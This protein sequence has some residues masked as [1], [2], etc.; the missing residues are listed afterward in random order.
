LLWYIFTLFRYTWLRYRTSMAKKEAIYCSNCS[1][2]KCYYIFF[3]II[4]PILEILRNW[5]WFTAYCMRLVSRMAYGSNSIES[6]KDWIRFRKVIL[7]W[8]IS[9]REANFPIGL[10]SILFS[11]LFLHI[12]CQIGRG[13]VSFIL[14]LRYLFVI[15]WNTN[16]Y[17]LTFFLNF[18][19]PSFVL[20]EFYLTSKRIIFFCFWCVHF[21][22]KQ[23]FYFKIIHEILLL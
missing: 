6:L 17:L 8:I 16:N 14:I 5:I 1:F 22:G 18:V 2:Y 21:I 19:Y 12:G 20:Q 9:I 15:A 10:E 7:K 3:H 13:D 4:V 11:Q 23:L